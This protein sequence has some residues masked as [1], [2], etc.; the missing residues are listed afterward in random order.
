MWKPVP[1][2]TVKQA[3]G[4]SLNTVRTATYQ[5][6]CCFGPLPRLRNAAVVC[7]RNSDETN[8]S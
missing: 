1:D 3:A 8:E 7:L 2:Q 5:S 6:C 4:D